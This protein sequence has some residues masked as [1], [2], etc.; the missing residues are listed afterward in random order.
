MKLAVHDDVLTM[1]GERKYEKE[2]TNKK[3][4]RVERSYGSFT[5]S[6]MLP[7]EADGSKVAADFKGGVLKVHVPK[8]QKAEPQSVEIKIA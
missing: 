1:T 4:H 7:E 5:R 8:S 2:E 3:F 6:F